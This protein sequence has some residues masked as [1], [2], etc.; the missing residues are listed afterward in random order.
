MH[1]EL[2]VA[3]RMAKEEGEKR[4]WKGVVGRLKNSSLA[5]VYSMITWKSG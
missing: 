1:T 3:L 4:G 2:G 5:D